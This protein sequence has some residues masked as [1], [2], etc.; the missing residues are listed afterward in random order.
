MCVVFLVGSCVLY[1]YSSLGSRYRLIFFALSSLTLYF[2]LSRKRPSL[3]TVLMIAAV[4]MLYL[5][6]IGLVRQTAG[7]SVA[8]NLISIDASMAFDRLLGSQ[9]DLNIFD[10]YTRVLE[11]VPEIIPFQLGRS[12]LYLLVHPVPRILWPDKPYPTES[13]MQVIYPSAGATYAYSLPGSLYIEFGIFGVVL[14]M[15]VFGIAW[16][17]FW[18][19]RCRMQG[20]IAADLLYAAAYPMLIF[21]TRGGFTANDTVWLLSYLIPILA[22]LRYSSRGTKRQTEG[23]AVAPNAQDTSREPRI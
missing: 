15:L 1:W 9:G 6:A 17:G 22:A 19:Y 5:N 14:G 20:R 4:G 12:V 2:L 8:E 7:F 23:V 3:L 10:S 18:L 16:R 11:A 21:Y 13:L